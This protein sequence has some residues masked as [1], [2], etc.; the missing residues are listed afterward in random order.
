MYLLLGSE[1]VGKYSGNGYMEIH[2]QL[3]YGREGSGGGT[4]RWTCPS[5]CGSDSITHES[6]WSCV[7]EGT[8]ALQ[9]V[10]ALSRAES[11]DIGGD[12]L[13]SQL[14]LPRR[15][16]S[17]RAGGL[18]DGEGERLVRST[19]LLLPGSGARLPRY[20]AEE[21]VGTGGTFPSSIQT[22]GTSSP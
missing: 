12:L 10:S 6:A 11:E 1:P 15:G 5:Q 2:V 21:E 8:Q 14:G 18:R 9:Q 20:S 7:E 4:R 3:C 16:S 13:H 22:T 19:V 17:S